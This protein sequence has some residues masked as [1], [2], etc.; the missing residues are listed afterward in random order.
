MV[1]DNAAGKSTLLKIIAGYHRPDK[2]EV[3][4]DGERVEFAS[5]LEARLA[6]IEMIYQQLL[7]APNLGVVDNIFLGREESLMGILLNRTRMRRRAEEILSKLGG[8]DIP[9]D[10]KV[11]TLSGGQQQIVAIGRIFASNPKVVLLDEPTA[12]LSVKAAQHVLEVVKELSRRGISVIYV[13][14]RLPDVLSISHRIMLLRRGKLVF[15]RPANEV[16]EHDI[17]RGMISE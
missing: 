12:S 13:S 10:S 17:I 3:Y 1:G 11:Y 15:I 16:T 7:L 9:L 4:L 2:G 8:D 6:G 5:P 14:H